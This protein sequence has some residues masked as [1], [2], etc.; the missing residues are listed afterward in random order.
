MEEIHAE[1]YI[2][3]HL[4]LSMLFALYPQPMH[5]VLPASV[6]GLPSL[7]TIPHLKSWYYFMMHVPY[8]L[9]TDTFW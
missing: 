9:G 8:A 7:V 2:C 6:A 4:V 3:G 5:A 1:G